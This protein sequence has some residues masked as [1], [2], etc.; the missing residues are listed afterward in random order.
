MKH[1]ITFKAKPFKLFR[2]E[3]DGFD[4]CIDFKKR[5]KKSDCSMKPCDHTYYNSDIFEGMLN[6]A[7]KQVIGEYTSFKRL[8]D[9]PPGVTVDTSKFLAVVTILLPETFK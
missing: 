1:T 6:R 8:D 5:V 3:N 4:L 9:M 2:H 7:Y